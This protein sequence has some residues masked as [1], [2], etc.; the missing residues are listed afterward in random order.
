M[1]WLFKKL[2]LKSFEDWYKI[3]SSDISGNIIF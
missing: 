2:N 3:K 1:D